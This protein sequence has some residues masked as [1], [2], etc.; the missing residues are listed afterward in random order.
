VRKPTLN[1]LINR[2]SSQVYNG[3]LPRPASHRLSWPLSHGSHWSRTN[4]ETKR[5]TD[6]YQSWKA[7]AMADAIARSL[8][9]IATIEYLVRFDPP[10]NQPH[11]PLGRRIV[12]QSRLGLPSCADRRGRAI[13]PDAPGPPGPS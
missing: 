8:L 3:D 11:L 13:F 12:A 2:K 4:A 10:I 9:R 1:T 7:Q 5:P 6:V